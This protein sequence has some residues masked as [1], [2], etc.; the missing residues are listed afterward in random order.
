M[1]E[2]RILLVDDEALIL[3]TYKSLLHQTGYVVNTAYSGRKALEIFSH[4]SFD[5]VI[6][7]LVM[8]DGDGFYLID[9]IKNKY[10]HIPV[11]VFTGKAS[12]CDKQFVSL[13]G[14]KKLIE[15]PCSNE[16]FIK[17]VKN[18]LQ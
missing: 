11:I 1:L 18:S 15:K 12:D 14:V 8:D 16:L 6:T 2:K 7:D 4:H 3:D 17:F 13:M 9:E 5:L 10:P